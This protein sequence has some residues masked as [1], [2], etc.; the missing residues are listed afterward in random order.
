[1][2]TKDRPEGDTLSSLEEAVEHLKESSETLWD[3]FPS[4]SLEEISK[5]G[6]LSSVNIRL[7]QEKIVY[8]IYVNLQALTLASLTTFDAVRFI[9]RMHL[10]SL[11]QQGP[12]GP[13]SGTPS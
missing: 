7:N 4:T 6:F 5:E 9:A 13:A 8:A 2:S 11:Q 3:L 12:A 10:M 1:M